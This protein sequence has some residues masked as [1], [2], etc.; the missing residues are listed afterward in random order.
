[1]S[2]VPHPVAGALP[3]WPD[4][5]PPSAA[6]ALRAGLDDEVA[7]LETRVAELTAGAAPEL[8]EAFRALVELHERRDHAAD[9]H[10]R[11][12]L[13]VLARVHTALAHLRQMPS[14]EAMIAAAP[15]SVCEAC[16]FDRAVLYRV[17]GKELLAEAFHVEGDPDSAARL[18]A[19]SRE[20]PAGLVTQALETEMIRR[21]RPMAIQQVVGNPRVFA[22]LAAAYDTRSYVAAPIMP[23]GR[24][25]GFIHADH[26]LKPRQVDEFD[27][28]ALWAFA[29]GFGYAVERARLT[30]R[31]RAQGQELRRLLQ[32]TEAVVA[33]YLDAEVELVSGSSEG[34]SRTTAALVPEVDDTIAGGLS[35]RELEVL[36]LVGG[37]A[38]NAQIAAR[39]V[40]TEETAKSHVKR[41]LRKLGASNR[42]EAAT[43]WLRAQPPR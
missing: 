9:A 43:I 4:D 41:I 10:M 33:E 18:L 40:I 29:E 12:R 13:Q 8:R 11:D 28:D 21:R 22:E 15:R 23:E 2:T 31:L 19:F 42:V 34:A 36:A 35:K 7:D 17:R 16:G 6:A 3:P 37:G 5:P 30:D 39:L 32:R 25:I 20:H 14:A 26:R 24:V 27:R 1:M 38:S